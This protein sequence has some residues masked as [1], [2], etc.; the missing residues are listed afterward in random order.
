MQHPI[1]ISRAKNLD[2]KQKVMLGIVIA[3][4]MAEPLQ[5][6]WNLHKA[7]IAL[8]EIGKKT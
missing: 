3:I 5:V 1:T 4:K 7:E 2:G 6:K 8:S